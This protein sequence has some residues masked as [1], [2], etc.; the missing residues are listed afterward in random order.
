MMAQ[1]KMQVVI[2][3]SHDASRLAASV[4]NLPNIHQQLPC[5]ALVCKTRGLRRLRENKP[6]D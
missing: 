4:S 5:D 2:S 6:D 1:L 3:L